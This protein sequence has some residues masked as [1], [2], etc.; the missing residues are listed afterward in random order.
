MPEERRKA[1]L[2]GWAPS[3][4][5]V[6]PQVVEPAHHTGWACARRAAGQTRALA[7]HHPLV[8][9]RVFAHHRAFCRP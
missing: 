2:A 6:Q 8:Y 7:W 1:S 5:L 3:H 9:D 4:W